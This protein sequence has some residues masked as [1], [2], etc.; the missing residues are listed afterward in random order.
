MLGIL[1][2]AFLPGFG[3]GSDALEHVYGLPVPAVYVALSFSL[4]LTYLP[5]GREHRSHDR[6]AAEHSD[7]RASKGER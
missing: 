6:L 3:A 5:H 4:A 1:A 7:A 2:R